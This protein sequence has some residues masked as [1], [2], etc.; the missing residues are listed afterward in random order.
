MTPARGVLFDYGGVLTTPPRWSIREW[1]RREGI[2]PTSFSRLLKTWLVRDAPVGNP[3]HQLE[4]G[5]LTAA[6]FNAVLTRE[7]TMADGTSVPESDHLAGAFS[8]IHPDPAMIR[9]VV[10][11]RGR[12]TPVALISNSWGNDYP[13]DVLELFDE[14]VIS[15]QVGLR[16]PQPEIYR[17]ALDR[18][19]LSPGETALV[20]DGGPNI[21]AATR[22]GLTGFLHTSAD[23]TLPAL[24]AALAGTTTIHDTKEIPR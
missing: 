11:L 2:D 18:L 3:L 13:A 9:Y 17:L 21:E 14:V 19:G 7:L 20:D 6:E 22:M 23:T 24:E 15:S 16:K 12:G 1:T 5:H 10:E 8:T 4:S